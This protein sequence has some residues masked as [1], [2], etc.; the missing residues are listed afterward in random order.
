MKPFELTAA[1][2]AA[3]DTFGFLSFP[4]LLAHRAGEISDAFERV[5]TE[6]GGGHAGKPHEGKARSCIV[7]FIDQSEVLSGLLEDP[8]V[9]AILTGLLGGDYNY[10]GSDGNYYVGDSQWHSDGYKKAGATVFAKM[11]F[12]LDP[13]TR[14][15][16]ALRVIPGS[17]R[18]GEPYA[19][20]LQ[21]Q[22]QQSQQNW[23]MEGR[24]VPAVALETTPGD[25][26]VF[27]HNTKHASF[28][29]SKT[30]RMF[31]IN[32]CQRIPGEQIDLL[33]SYIAGF[34]RFWVDRPYGPAMLAGP[35][36]RGVHLEQVLA[37]EDH[38]PALAAKAR[39]EMPEPARG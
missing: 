35:D 10:M 24:Q 22:I 36:R 4:G 33:K 17:H 18:A 23:N 21:A 37:N 31:T 7:P 27:N 11:A 25:V 8:A 5:W 16:G 26:V 15:T 38:L 32:C 29:G 2:K 20:Q 34:A 30:R 6:R 12:Y 39:R 28:G 3:F 19:D 1:D 13:L 14:D 9:D